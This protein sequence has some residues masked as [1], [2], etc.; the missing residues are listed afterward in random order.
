M[1]TLDLTTKVE[2]DKNCKKITQAH[3]G[4]ISF[5]NWN[6]KK[7]GFSCQQVVRQQTNFYMLH[8]F[9]RMNSPVKVLTRGRGRLGC[10]WGVTK[11][12]IT[13]QKAKTLE[14]YFRQF[15]HKSN[16]RN[17]NLDFYLSNSV[18]LVAP[19]MVNFAP[20][21]NTMSESGTPFLTLLN[22]CN[23]TL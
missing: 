11:S 16:T 12:L 20:K 21:Q 2:Q 5:H 18:G 7:K 23:P 1:L 19:K 8:K 22:F 13:K 6:E 14:I 3:L 10:S 4:C 15:C 9:S 17:F